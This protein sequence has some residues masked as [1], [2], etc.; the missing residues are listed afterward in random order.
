[1]TK[2]EKIKQSIKETRERRKSQV[3]KV[4]ELKLQKLSS[5]DKKLFERMFLEAKW[6]YNYIVA[7][8]ESRLNGQA[9]KIKQVFVK[10]PNGT[11]LRKID[12]LSAQIR[13][14]I[15]NKIKYNLKGLKSLK[16][17]GYK[18]G[19]LKF[20]SEVKS[21]PL[22][23]YGNTHRLLRDKNRVKIQ[24]IKKKFRVLGLRQIP[25]NAEIANAH[26][27]K[28]PSGYYIHITCF[29]PKKSDKSKNQIKKPVGVDFGIRNQMTLSNGLSIKW[30]YPETP[31]LKNLQKQFSKKVKGSKNRLK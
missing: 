16:E 4:F 13:Q 8:I 15:V 19:R 30:S 1:M 2:A 12:R 5:N 9:W 29:L 21:I 14:G 3:C 27:I 10:T 22:V 7:D 31:R 23:Q 11:S 28:K 18:V 20:K 6:L 25:K 17:K 26:L 24:G